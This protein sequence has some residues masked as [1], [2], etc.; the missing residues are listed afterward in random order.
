MA[1]IGGIPHFQTYPHHPTNTRRLN[2]EKPVVSVAEKVATAEVPHFRIKDHQWLILG[3]AMG[4]CAYQAHMLHSTQ[5][6]SMQFPHG[7][8]HP[9]QPT[10]HHWTQVH[11]EVSPVFFMWFQ[12]VICHHISIHIWLL[13]HGCVFFLISWGFNV[14][15]LFFTMGLL[16]GWFIWLSQVKLFFIFV[17]N[18]Q[19]TRER[20]PPWGEA[21][22][23]T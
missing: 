22:S 10:N 5:S 2:A 20:C 23:N 9:F 3:G 19:C 4:P 11:L 18:Q 16:M 8:W 15:S 12:S 7:R 1:I 14:C 6:N 13:R 21:S 17:R